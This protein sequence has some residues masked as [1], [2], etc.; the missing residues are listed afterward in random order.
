MDNGEA[1]KEDIDVEVEP[2]DVL[3]SYFGCL[4]KIYIGLLKRGYRECHRYLAGI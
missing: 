2:V 3:D 4:K 1:L